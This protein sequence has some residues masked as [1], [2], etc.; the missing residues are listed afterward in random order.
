M[1][2]IDPGTQ[3]EGTKTASHFT[4]IRT[5]ADPD[6][7]AATAPPRDGSARW[8]RWVLARKTDFLEQG[9]MLTEL[10]KKRGQLIVFFPKCHCELNWAELFWSMLKSCVRRHVDGAWGAMAASVWLAFGEEN[11]PLTLA[12]AFGRKF[13]ELP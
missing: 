9:N 12:R 2:H 11:T 13:R 8:M 4:E 10:V 7:E 6:D 1:D 3:H 5:E